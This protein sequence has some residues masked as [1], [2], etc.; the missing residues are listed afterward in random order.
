MYNH[1]CI[2]TVIIIVIIILYRHNHH[3]GT[4][5][6]WNQKM[7]VSNTMEILHRLV[8]YSKHFDLS[9][10]DLGH[11]CIYKKMRI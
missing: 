6:Q 3:P 9:C 1:S 2:I 11:P 10:H 4:G 7:C 5:I 8:L